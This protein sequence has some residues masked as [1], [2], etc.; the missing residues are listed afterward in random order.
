M[1]LSRSEVVV[2]SYRSYLFVT[3]L[4]GD[5]CK[6]LIRLVVRYW[7]KGERK[8]WKEYGIILLL[9]RRELV[10]SLIHNR[11]ALMRVL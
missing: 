11:K 9:K 7:G 4:K 8:F 10:Q 2:S 5:A 1:H 6:H 3:F